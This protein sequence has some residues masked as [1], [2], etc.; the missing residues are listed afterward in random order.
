MKIV[1]APDSF[2]ESLSAPEVAAALA[3][4]EL[5]RGPS[6]AEMDAWARSLRWAN[7]ARALVGARPQ[8]VPLNHARLVDELLRVH[9][10][11]VLV[12]GAFNGDP[13]PGNLLV[14]RLRPGAREHRL[15][16]VDYGQVKTL[17]REERL[18]VARQQ[19]KSLQSDLQTHET[20][21]ATALRQILHQVAIDR[22]T[23]VSTITGKQRDDLQAV[24]QLCKESDIEVPLQFTNF[25]D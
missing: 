7:W 18:K 24:I 14:T 15:A 2:K 1:I 25:R 19:Q 3:R 17:T 22:E 20:G 21:T 13:H 11:E 12:D 9:A 4:G 5:R 10:H 6:A 8:H 23:S 16:L